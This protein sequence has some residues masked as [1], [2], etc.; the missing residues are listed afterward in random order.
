MRITTNID[1]ESP[2]PICA[3]FDPATNVIALFANERRYPVSMTASSSSFSVEI[4]PLV[5]D[6]FLAAAEVLK[7]KPK[8]NSR[9]VPHPPVGLLA[10]NALR[11]TTPA[12]PS[13]ALKV[14]NVP[15]KVA[16][17]V[18]PTISDSDVLAYKTN[19]NL[20]E[21]L[22]AIPSH[23]IAPADCHGDVRQPT[24]PDDEID[25]INTFPAV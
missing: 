1:T 22:N 11:N 18:V 7:A 20:V 21:F 3:W 16:V 17:E 5:N 2:H 6:H 24:P 15:Q 25:D 10:N 13:A 8:E 23:E 4:T 14:R 9:L 19:G 12:L